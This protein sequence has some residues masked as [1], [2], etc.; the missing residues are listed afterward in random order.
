V[1]R[2]LAG[3]RSVAVIIGFAFAATASIAMIGLM[4]QRR[5]H[6]QRVDAIPE[7]TTV[8]LNLPV[9]ALEREVVNAPPNAPRQR[10][11]NS[12]FWSLVISAVALGVVLYQTLLMI[13][14]TKIMDVQTALS[15]KQTE[16]AQKQTEIVEKQDKLLARRAVLTARAKKVKTE[17]DRITYS[18][19][20]VNLG[21]KGASGYHWHF[22][23]P[24]LG[25][26]VVG[27]RWKVAK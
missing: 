21:E 12:N 25:G 24:P 16:L 2:I 19:V 17:G 27:S 18:I 8:S 20:A 23:I 13:R 5:L 4:R 7:P 22:L 15:Q 6:R 1:W 26:P 10:R 11:F 9:D 3:W 14:Q